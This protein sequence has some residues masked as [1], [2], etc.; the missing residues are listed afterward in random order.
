MQKYITTMSN[1]ALDYR[2]T[3]FQTQYPIFLGKIAIHS[4]NVSCIHTIVSSSLHS[5]H[6]CI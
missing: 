3:S 1:I 6:A 2:A 5:A 4:Y